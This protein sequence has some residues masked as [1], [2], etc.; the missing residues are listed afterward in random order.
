MDIPSLLLGIAIGSIVTAILAVIKALR[1]Y[2]KYEAGELDLSQ[3]SELKNEPNKNQ[4]K[5]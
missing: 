2:A 4:R 5:S 1:E 3:I